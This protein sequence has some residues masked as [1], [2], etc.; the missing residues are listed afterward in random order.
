MP[1]TNSV[2]PF[3]SIPAIQTI[4]PLL[5]VR[6]TFFTALFLCILEA[7]VIFF[8]SRI[9]LPGL[10]GFFSTWKLTFLPTIIAESS[11]MFVSFVFTVPIYLPFL[12]TEH[13]SATAMISA[14]L[15][16]MK[17]IDLPSAAR[18]FIISISSA[19]SWGVRT[20]VGSS[21]IRI[22]LSRYS[23]FKISVL[24]CIPTV[25]SSIIASGST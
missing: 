23:I 15:W 13:L 22:S 20:A 4:S 21:K 24:C 17:S 16:E 5:T 11:S 3:P 10:H 1:W 25:M 9:G 14:S 18:F 8:T 12:R 2:W 6:D 7:T 19:I